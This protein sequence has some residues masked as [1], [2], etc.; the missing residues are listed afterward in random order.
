MITP[1]KLKE[2][3]ATYYNE[4]LIEKID[5]SILTFHG[6][7]PWETAIIEGEFLVEQR[8]AIA[9]KY[10]EDG[11]NYVYHRTSSE[12]GE[13]PGLTTFLFSNTP[14]EHAKNGNYH[15]CKKEITLEKPV[16]EELE[17]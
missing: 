12:N 1:N 17:I 2:I 15:I 3:D 11:W 7:Y 6:F 8:N 14:I 10:I 4:Q 9:Q 5:N 16:E 13:R